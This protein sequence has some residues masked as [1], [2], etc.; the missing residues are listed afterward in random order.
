MVLFPEPICSTTYTSQK[1]SKVRNP[2]TSVLRYHKP[3]PSLKFSTNPL[4]SLTWRSLKTYSS[5]FVQPYL[6]VLQILFPILSPFLTRV[7]LVQYSPPVRLLS[8]STNRHRTLQ[9]QFTV[10]EALA[11]RELQVSPISGPRA[12]RRS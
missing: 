1:G 2:L 4:I 8:I 3:A 11:L 10:W 12:S 5:S 9:A 7:L 6:L